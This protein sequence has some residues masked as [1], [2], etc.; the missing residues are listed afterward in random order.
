MESIT[1]AMETKLGLRKESIE[2]R[3]VQACLDFGLPLN[4]LEAF[5]ASL[6]PVDLE[7]GQKQDGY[8]I[9][10][11]AFLFTTEEQHRIAVFDR[12]RTGSREK[13]RLTHGHGILCLTTPDLSGRT[14][15]EEQILQKVSG[16]QIREAKILGQGVS[17][18][19]ANTYL[20]TILQVDVENDDPLAIKHSRDKFVGF[21]GLSEAKGLLGEGRRVD[22]SILSF[23]SDKEFDK[24]SFTPSKVDCWIQ[25]NIILGVDIHR[26]STYASHEQVLKY[27]TLQVHIG[28]L[29]DELNLSAYTIQTGDG[30][31]IVFSSCTE[32]EALNFCLRLQNCIGAT[33]LSGQ[34][35]G[36]PL[37]RYAL[38]S[39]FV[40]KVLDLNQQ[41]NF[42][43]DGINYCARLMNVKEPNVLY[44]SKD[45]REALNQSDVING[46]DFQGAQLQ[47]KHKTEPDEVFFLSL[48]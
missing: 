31:F 13:Q 6:Q 23:L 10:Q 29:L 40:Y 5:G 37:L 24:K 30:C 1:V 36:L 45:F 33:N 20:L 32:A 26:F 41:V 12:A 16:I 48:E 39:G 25:R 14:S 7:T 18:R 43:G 17:D 44:V 42:I 8:F 9:F 27:I 4:I 11:V 22:D 19:G 35:A 38:N 28:N 47:I 3:R 15:F 2:G 21:A 34:D 46:R